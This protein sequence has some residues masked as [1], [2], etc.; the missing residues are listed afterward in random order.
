MYPHF[1]MLDQIKPPF[2]MVKPSKF[3]AAN[4]LSQIFHRL[5]WGGNF[6]TRNETGSS[7]ENGANIYGKCGC[8]WQ[9]TTWVYLKMV[10]SPEMYLLAERIWST[11]EWGTWMGYLIFRRT[12]FALNNFDG[13]ALMNAICLGHLILH[14]VQQARLN[15]WRLTMSNHL[16]LKH[17]ETILW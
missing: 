11:C 17:L 3:G 4:D 7:S 2:L 12:P 16:Y 13:V 8:R 6:T 9:H 15:Y 1:R 5:V 10:S 14:V